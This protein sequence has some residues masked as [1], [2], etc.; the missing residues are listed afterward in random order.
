MG[1][2]NGLTRDQRSALASLDEFLASN[3]QNVFILKGYA[4]TG[5]TFLISRIA[6]RLRSQQRS[7]VLLAPTGRAAKPACTAI[8][9][10]HTS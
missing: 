10:M 4:G 1:V 9:G 7:V 3:D 6:K 2:D 5:K 8:P